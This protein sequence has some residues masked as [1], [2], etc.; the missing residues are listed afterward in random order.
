MFYSSKTFIRAHQD[1]TKPYYNHSY[2]RYVRDAICSSCGKVIGG[3]VKYTDWKG[4]FRFDDE[5]DKY[6]HCP[7]CGHKFKGKDDISE[8]VKAHLEK[9]H[10]TL[11]INLEKAKN[12]NG[13]K[14]EEIDALQRK[15]EI[16][17]YLQ[18]K[19]K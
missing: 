4:D 13:V 2:D 19:C 10:N 12:R 1:I 14:Q 18:Q 17:A 3:Q 11:T 15:I 8:S 7:Y 5:K 16:N 6:T 9:E